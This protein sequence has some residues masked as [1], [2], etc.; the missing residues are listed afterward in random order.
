MPDSIRILTGGKII[1]FIGIGGTGMN[2]LASMLA[3]LGH[4]I[5]GSDFQKTPTTQQLEKSGIK[6]WYTHKPKHISDTCGLVV[7]SAAISADNPEITKAHQLGIKIRKYSEMLGLLMQKKQG[8]AISGSHGKTTI[9]ALLSYLLTRAGQDPSYIIG[10]YVPDLTSSAGRREGDLTGSAHPGQGDYFIAEACEYDRSFHNLSY[11]IALINNIEPDHLDYYKDL[12]EIIEA[13]HVFAQQISPDGFILVNA[14]NAPALK[15]VQ[16]L[17]HKIIT[18]GLQSSANWQAKNIRMINNQ[19][20]FEV[21]QDNQPRL[22]GIKINIPG[23]FNVYNALAV[24]AIS[25]LIGIDPKIIKPALADFQG[26]ERRFQKVGSI[27][28]ALV[29]DDYGHHPTELKAVLE[30][31]R[32]TF[33][34]RRIWCVFQPHQASRTKCFLS[35]FVQVFVSADKVILPDIYFAR[36]SEMAKHEVTSNDLVEKINQAGGQ[37]QYLPHFPEIIA[38]LKENLGN[39]DLV[40]TFGAGDVWQV[41]HGLCGK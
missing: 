19:W 41:A 33:P 3:D 39:K 18:F 10:G 36:D 37:A 35:D 8:I 21:W 27:N 12:N 28:G 13:F 34:D 40:I 26:V 24:I 25:Q 29:L 30:T 14:D 4:P 16:D 6:I 2:A 9:S 11:K 7:Y 23:R 1:H 38:Y 31:I 15:A 17:P 5:T 32:I 20:Y 22:G